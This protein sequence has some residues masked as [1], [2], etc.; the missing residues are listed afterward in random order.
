LAHGNYFLNFLRPYPAR[1]TNPEP[2]SRSVAGSGV[3][4]GCSPVASE[5][6]GVEVTDLKLDVVPGSSDE[7]GQPTIPKNIITIH[8]TINNFFIFFS[9]YYKNANMTIPS[10]AFSWTD[11]TTINLYMYA[12]IV[13]IQMNLKSCSVLK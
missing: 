12:K 3:A 11:K 8:K 6:T 13:Q 9:H 5:A 2:S 7:L 1:P 4:R 10:L